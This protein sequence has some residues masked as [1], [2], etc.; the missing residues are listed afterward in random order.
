[1][2]KDAGF[3]VPETCHKKWEGCPPFYTQMWG[4]SANLDTS[5][6]KQKK[7]HSTSETGIGLPIYCSVNVRSHSCLGLWVFQ[8]CLFQASNDVT[9]T[10]STPTRSYEIS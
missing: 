2:K 5:E 6:L 3:Q 8:K 7:R 1:M 10:T 4:I 9:S